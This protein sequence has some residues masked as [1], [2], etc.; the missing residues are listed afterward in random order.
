MTTVVVVHDNVDLRELAVITRP[1][2]AAFSI[3][4]RGGKAR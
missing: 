2:V 1:L 4:S 3:M